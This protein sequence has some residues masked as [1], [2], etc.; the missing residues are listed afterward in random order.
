MHLSYLKIPFLKMMKMITKFSD[1]KNE[2]ECKKD[3]KQLHKESKKIVESCNG[4]VYV[5]NPPTHIIINDKDDVTN[6]I[7]RNKKRL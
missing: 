3:R 2:K 6:E 1:F 7:I 4:I 5:D